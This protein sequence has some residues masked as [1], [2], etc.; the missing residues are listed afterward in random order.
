MRFQKDAYGIPMADLW[1]F[2]DVSMIFY[3][4]EDFFGMSESMPWEFYGI[5]TGFL[6][7]Y[8]I[9]MVFL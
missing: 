4:L 5:L 1:D 8:G 9:S 7:S 6:D 3:R 2:H